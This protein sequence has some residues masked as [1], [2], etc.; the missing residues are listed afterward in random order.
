MVIGLGRHFAR[1]TGKFTFEAL[2][3]QLGPPNRVA[4]RP[5]TTTL[6]ARDEPP[7]TH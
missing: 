4:I 7:L 2:D 5:R 6:G 1:L 3:C